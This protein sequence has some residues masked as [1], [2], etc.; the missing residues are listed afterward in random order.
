MPIVAVLFDLDGT[1]VD[2]ERESAEGMARFLATRGVVVDE[3]DRDFVIGHSWN[4]IYA[5]LRTR[6]GVTLPLAE[7]VAGSARE[8]EQVLAAGVR[9]LPGARD[10]IARLR[11]RVPLGLVSGSSR[12]ELDFSLASAGLGGAFRVTIASE[13]VAEGKPSP[14]GFRLCAERLGVAPGGCLVIEDSRAGIAAAKAAGMR[15][16][17]VRAGNFARQDQSAADV[18]IDTLEE[19]DDAFLARTGLS[20]R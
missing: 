10:A 12:R 2:T 3:A 4:E 15:C 1:L 14:L 11:A 13:D 20:W 5:R 6:H 18:V 19:V 7:V 9:L 8:R 16:V 17:A